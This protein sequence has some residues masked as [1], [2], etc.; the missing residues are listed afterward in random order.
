[1]LGGSVMSQFYNKYVQKKSDLSQILERVYK[2]F[3]EELKDF[4]KEMF[5]FVDYVSLLDVVTAKSYVSLKEN[6]CKA[7]S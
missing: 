2:L 7:N 3:V 6:Y 5:N 1:M 4:D